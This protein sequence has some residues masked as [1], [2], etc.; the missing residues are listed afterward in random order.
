V[1]DQGF[2][3]ILVELKQP[4]KKATAKNRAHQRLAESISVPSRASPKEQNSARIQKV[5][6]IQTPAGFYLDPS[7]SC[8]PLP[9]RANKLVRGSI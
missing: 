3:V 4:M 9:K 1:S 7:A 6:G 8:F 5:R 2:D